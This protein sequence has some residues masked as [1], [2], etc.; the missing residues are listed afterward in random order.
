M[1]KHTLKRNLVDPLL[2]L[3]ISPGT[4]HFNYLALSGFACISVFLE[5]APFYHPQPLQARPEA[6]WKR[7]CHVIPNP[8]VCLSFQLHAV[9]LTS[10]TGKSTKF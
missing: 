5:S 6:T 9:L 7:D 10:A 2:R 8:S 3:R 4:S 1:V